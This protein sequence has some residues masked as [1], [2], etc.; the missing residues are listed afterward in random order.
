MPFFSRDKLPTYTENAIRFNIAQKQVGTYQVAV[1]KNSSVN[2]GM[3][4]ATIQVRFL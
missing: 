4:A 1:D 2:A 3:R